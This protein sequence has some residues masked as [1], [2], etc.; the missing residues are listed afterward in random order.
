MST[1][2]CILFVDDDADVQKAAAM[3]LRRHG[4]DLL[5]ARTPEEAF[6]VLAA[7]RV[8]VVLLDLNFGPGAVSGAEGLRCLAG[9]IAHDPDAVVVV[10]TGHSGVNIAVAA[11]RAGAADFVMKPWNNDRLVATLRD[12]AARRQQRRETRAQGAAP[13]G[14]GD[15]PLIGD[16]RAMRQVQAL[17][18]RVAGSD[19]AVLLTGEPGT[20]KSLLAQT[21]HRRSGRVGL[22]LVTIDPTALWSEGEAAWGAALAAADPRGTVFLDEV[23]SLPQAAQARLARWIADHSHVRLIASSRHG[24]AALQQGLLGADLLDRLGTVDIALPPL[25]DRGADVGLL[26]EHFLRVFA[27]RYAQPLPALH[28][29]AMVAIA[30]APWPGN[31]RELRQAIERAVVLADGGTLQTKDVI[32][33]IVAAGA[34]V[35]GQSDLNLERSERAVVQAAL[36][37]HGFNITR[38]AAELGLTRAALYRR[39]ARHGL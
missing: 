26:A 10:V 38:A 22:P 36:S 25:R 8:D 30:A 4:F 15:M 32:P 19:A 7:S 29:D 5:T 31:V 34:A 39:M 17:L 18:A 27:R 2:P 33:P 14:E 6:S 11:M 9:L 3:L 13:A 35:P 28:P 37:R 20:G 24:R 1:P 16:S 23:G 12:A 21:I